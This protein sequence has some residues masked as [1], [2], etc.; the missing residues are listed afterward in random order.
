M[1]VTDAEI[2]SVATK[3]LVV[4]GGSCINTAAATLV[5]GA[6][7]GAAWTEATGVGSGQ[8]IV[9]GYADSSLTSRM[10]LLVAGYEADDTTNAATYLRNK[11]P[12]TSGETIM[13]LS[14]YQ[15]L[16]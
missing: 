10:A 3:N 1:L 8:F 11:K 4:V 16:A 12:D 6:Y 2:A 14:E 15:A 7:C 9:K 5:G 13:S